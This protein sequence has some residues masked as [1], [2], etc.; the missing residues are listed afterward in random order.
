MNKQN[1]KTIMQWLFVALM[2]IGGFM[3]YRDVQSN[4]EQAAVAP[5]AEVVASG[6]VTSPDEA[7]R[8]SGG[9]TDS[10]PNYDPN[11]PYGAK[12]GFGAL[13]ILCLVIII[14]WAIKSAFRAMSKRSGGG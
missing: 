3:L 14:D 8:N 13:G 10:T 6:A 5:S 4:I 7:Q 11:D 12:F 1:K 9:V 2:L